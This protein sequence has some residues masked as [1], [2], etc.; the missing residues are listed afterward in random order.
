MFSP[1]VSKFD[2]KLG[3]FFQR[4]DEFRRTDVQCIYEACMLN[5]EEGT[6]NNRA[7]VKRKTN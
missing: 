1:F 5:T 6:G 3:F 7:A 4:L 2:H